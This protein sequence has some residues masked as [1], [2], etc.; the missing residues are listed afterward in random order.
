MEKSKRLATTVYLEPKVARAV[1][2]KAALT[3][4]SVSDLVNEALSR[5]LRE[6][7][8]DL[9]IARKR[10]S[11]RARPLEAILKELKRDGLL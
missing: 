6:D 4:R 3:D 10:G 7:E 9:S 2:V 8:E 11:E 1:R 5:R